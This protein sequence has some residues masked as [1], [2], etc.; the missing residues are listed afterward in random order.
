MRQPGNEAGTLAT[1]YTDTH[2]HL[3]YIKRGSITSDNNPPRPP[4]PPHIIPVLHPFYP[5]LTVR[6]QTPRVPS[7]CFVRTFVLSYARKVLS[8]ALC[9]HHYLLPLFLACSADLNGLQH[10]VDHKRQEETID[11]HLL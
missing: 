6:I 8:L 11:L 9:S 5:R 10:P 2:Q 4:L 7:K 3:N 1:T